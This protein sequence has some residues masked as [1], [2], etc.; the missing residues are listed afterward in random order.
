MIQRPF[1]AYKGDDPYIFVS[2]AHDDSAMVFPEISRLK[3]KGFNIWYDEGIAPGS[4]WSDEVALAL[5]QCKLFIYMITPRSVESENCQQELNFAMSRERKILAVHLEKTQLTMGVELRLSTKQAILKQ[6]YS[7]NAY[8][9]KLDEAIRSLMPSVENG[10]S[11]LRQE[12]KFPGQQSLAILS[13]LNRS[14]DPQNDFLCDGIAAEL[15]TGLSKISGLTVAPQLT[16]FGFSEQDVDV[17]SIG[18]KLNIA[19]V[20]TGILQQSG[21]RIR[22]TTNLAETSQGN[23]IWSERYD[24]TMSDVFDLQEDVAN[25]IIRALKMQLDNN[26]ENSVV[27]VGTNNLDAYRCFCKGKFEAQKATLKSIYNAS[28]LFNEAAAIDPAYGKAYW[29]QLL[30]CL[31]KRA[32]SILSD[33]E[34]SVEAYRL[35]G[36][37]NKTTYRI[38]V[39]QIVLDRMIDP[40]KLPSKKEV[41][42]EALGKIESEDENWRGF[43]YKAL[44]QSLMSVGLLNGALDYFRFYSQKYAVD[45]EYLD[46]YGEQAKIMIALGK[47]EQTIDYFSSILSRSPDS[48][49]ELATRA[50]LYSR[51][52]QYRKAEE[53]LKRLSKFLPVSFPHFYHLYWK[54]DLQAAQKYVEHMEKSKNYPLVMRA[55]SSLLLDRLDLAFE[56]MENFE[57]SDFDMTWITLRYCV[58][59][60]IMRRIRDHPKY[61]NIKKL[62][63]LDDD[64][65]DELMDKV[66]KL[67]PITGIHVSPDDDY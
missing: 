14:S 34:C 32:M 41:A 31:Q 52:G 40:E 15:T 61:Q 58:T 45:T 54:R 19:H 25:N 21:E 18:K 47:F 35:I 16:S 49:W 36:E 8:F 66:N 67:E 60:S 4:T 3:D 43:E 44:G 22:I 39:P 2:Y 53:D 1:R 46:F 59:P 13:F 56:Y 57:K 62:H 42:L 51:T 27:D 33:A 23:I 64:W 10:T 6:D 26:D 50:M 65:R 38:P 9:E 63:E 24:G 12:K 55:I 5:T 30:A 48:I 11:M 29:F 20:L 7:K 28:K 37:I 17:V